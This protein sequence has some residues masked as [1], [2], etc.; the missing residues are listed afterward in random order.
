MSRLLA[1]P[2]AEP[3]Q[4]CCRVRSFPPERHDIRTA[5]SAVHENL[6]HFLR[7]RQEAFP[8][9]RDI[10][11]RHFLTDAVGP[12]AELYPVPAKIFLLD[13]MQPKGYGFPL[14]RSQNLDDLETRLERWISEEL[15]VR[16]RETT[17]SRD[18]LDGYRDQVVRLASNAAESSV[19]ADYHS[20]F[21][22]LQTQQVSKHFAAFTRRAIES[23]LAREEADRLKYVLHGKWAGAMREVVQVKGFVKLA[24]ENPLIAAEEFISPDL[25]ELRA[26]VQTHLRRDFNDFRK[27]FEALRTSAAHLLGND[28]ILRRALALLGYPDTAIPPLVALLDPRVWQLLGEHPSFK[29][30]AELSVL[31]SASRK[32]LEFLVVQALRRGIIWM[33]T[34]TEGDNVGDDGA[35]EVYSRAIRPMNFGRRG[36]VEPIVYRYGLVYDITS[37]TETLGEIARGGKGEEQSSY[38]QMLEFQRELA[39]ITRSHGLQFEKFLGDGAFY[40]SRRA[41]RTVQAAIEVQQFYARK[42]ASG[43]AFNKGMRIALNYG[44]YRLLPMQ[45]SADGTQIMEFYGPGIVELSRLTT[46]KATKEL[47]DIQHL[48]LA[49]GYDQNDV[50]R[51]FAPLSRSVDHTDTN[52]QQ[53]EFYAYVNENGHLINEGIV[54]S[55]PFLR[56]LSTEI[57]EDQQKLYRLRAP[58]NVYLGFPTSGEYGGYIGIRLLGSVSLKGIGSQDIG[59]AVWLSPDTA[60]ISMIDEARPLLQ[61]LQQERN[62]SAARS[63]NAALAASDSEGGSGDLVVCEA[64][65]GS[66]PV[67][68]VGEWDPVSE[69]VRRP[70]RLDEVDAERY[71]L[72]V[73]LT[74]QAVESQSVA[75]QKLYRKL[76]RLETLP[77]FSVDAIRHNSNFSGFIIGATVEPL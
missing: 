1:K 40:T 62:R 37:F 18:L 57:A 53:R 44:Y 2:T 51:F 56:Q 72:A 67:I 52:Q 11:L 6:I 5:A 29:T 19:L 45:V 69:E 48:L 7:T 70:I 61:S 68:L 35:N 65:S 39:D 49:H 10:D 58:W 66:T 15:E 23:G 77:S 13:E 16:G 33:K 46:G 25:R 50:Y 22:L 30:P 31:E 60:E 38:R 55:I 4:F 54:V 26:Y 71:G 21:W 34:T 24:L 32:I 36:V 59:E 9:R 8:F 20:V 3:I 14:T 73:P 42:R 17:R 74:V 27:S 41:T 63:M 28:R 76:S 43:F 64:T 12:A 47:E 75:Y